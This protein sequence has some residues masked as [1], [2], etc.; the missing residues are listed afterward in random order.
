LKNKAHLSSALASLLWLTLAIQ[1]F[2]ILF[3]KQTADHILLWKGCYIG[4]WTS[5]SNCVFLMQKYHPSNRLPGSLSAMHLCSA[6]TTPGLKNH[7]DYFKGIGHFHP[8]YKCASLYIQPEQGP[9]GASVRRPLLLLS[10]FDQTSWH[11]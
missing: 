7:P 8:S 2:S 5:D 6:Q 11:G 4:V 1:G 9:T 10:L 3:F